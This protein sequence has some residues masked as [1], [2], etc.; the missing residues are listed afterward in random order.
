VSE[1]NPQ[2]SRSAE[3]ATAPKHPHQ[4]KVV[5][6]VGGKDGERPAI[7]RET[8]E[9]ATVAVGLVHGQNHNTGI[10]H[11]MTEKVK[12][13]KRHGNQSKIERTELPLV[14]QMLSVFRASPP[15]ILRNVGKHSKSYSKGNGVSKLSGHIGFSSSNTE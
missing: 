6:A 4:H 10:G 5:A 1:L 2:I 14:R 3:D 11:H 7:H 13:H 8:L 15:H 9:I 12:H